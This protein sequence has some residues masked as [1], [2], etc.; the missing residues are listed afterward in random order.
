MLTDSHLHT[1][2]DEE[3]MEELKR[4]RQDAL[5]FLFDRY[6][7]LVFSVALKILHDRGEAEDLMQEVFIEIYRR[8]EIFNPAKGSAKTWILQ[9][10]YHRSLN[11]RKYLALRNF[12]DRTEETDLES[13][14]FAHS[15]SEWNGLTYQEWG[16]MIEKGLQTLSE[17]ERRTLDLTY[18]QGFQL[19]DIAVQLGEPLS[20]V[21]NH[22]Y[23]GLK[24]LRAFLQ[25]HGCLNK[26]TEKKD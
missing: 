2:T 12:Y 5:S 26:K 11:R 20:N 10:A 4:G 16:Q 18:F 3:L 9:Y 17:R 19:K 24:K 23:R 13:Y 22:Y 7:R 25:A 8:I 14:E 6:Y 21:R 1:R 15:M